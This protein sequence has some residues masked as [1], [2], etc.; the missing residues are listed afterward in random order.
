MLAERHPIPVLDAVGFDEPSHT[1]TALGKRVPISVTKLTGRHFE[2]FDADRV[3][4]T[5]FSKWRVNASSPRIP[6]VLRTASHGL[7]AL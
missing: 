5:W 3:I 7:K 1:Y 4:N 6:Q 2:A